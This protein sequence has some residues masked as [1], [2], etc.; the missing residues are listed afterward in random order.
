MP[1]AT[2][3]A[4]ATRLVPNLSATSRIPIRA[5]NTTLVSLIAATSASGAR[6]WAQSTVPYATSDSAPAAGKGLLAGAL[7]LVA[8]GTVL[9]AQTRAPLAEVAAIRE[10]SV[11]FAALIGMRLFAEGFGTRRVVAA[12]LVAAGILLISA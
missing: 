12:A 4:A 1:A 6:V 7:S 5:A 9:W 8:Y 11:V 3:A 10:T 2:S